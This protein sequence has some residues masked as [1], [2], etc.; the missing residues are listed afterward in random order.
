MEPA[1]MPKRVCLCQPD[2]KQAAASAERKFM[3][4]KPLLTPEHSSTGTCRKSYRPSKPDSSTSLLN[5]CCGTSTGKFRIIN[6]VV[7]GS[8]RR[9]LREM[10]GAAAAM[11]HSSGSAMLSA[12]AAASSAAACLGVM[13]AAAA[14]SAAAASLGVMAAEAPLPLPASSPKEV[15]KDKGPLRTPKPRPRRPRCIRLPAAAA[16]AIVVDGVAAMPK[17]TTWAG[18]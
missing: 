9:P 14:P 5:S 17:V 16:E 2:W 18:V 12:A 8:D 13:A 7:F 10:H 3:K 1:G 6:V 4:A 11:T 15:N